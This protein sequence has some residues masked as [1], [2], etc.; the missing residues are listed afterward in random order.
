M[1]GLLSELK[2][3]NKASSIVSDYETINSKLTINYQHH[4]VCE[5]AEYH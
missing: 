4:T 5:V 1:W 2:L 3:G